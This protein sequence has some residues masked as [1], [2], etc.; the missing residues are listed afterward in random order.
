V[1]CHIA[2]KSTKG[3]TEKTYIILVQHTIEQLTRNRYNKT[4][5]A[6]TKW[7]IWPIWNGT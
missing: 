6:N 2:L 3:H 4:K 5:R 7:P 1:L